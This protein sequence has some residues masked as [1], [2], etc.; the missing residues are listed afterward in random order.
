M[1]HQRQLAVAR[2]VEVVLKPARLAVEEVGGHEVCVESGLAYT[3][4][5]VLTLEAGAELD[6]S[7]GASG[8]PGMQARG[9]AHPGNGCGQAALPHPPRRIHSRDDEPRDTY[10]SSALDHLVP[11]RIEGWEVEVAVSIDVHGWV[12]IAYGV[13]MRMLLLLLL[14]VPPGCEDSASSGPHIDDVQPNPARPGELL[15]ITGVGFGERGYVGLG[16]LGVRSKPWSATELSVV[17]PTGT[18]GGPLEVVVLAEGRPSAP[19]RIEVLGPARRHVPPPRERVRIADARVVRPPADAGIPPDGAPPDVPRHLVARFTAD[20]G[21][22]GLVTLEG[23]DSVPGELRLR[24]RG[25]ITREDP[26]WGVAFHLAYD[27]NLLRFIE[28]EDPRRELRVM[29]KEIAPGQLAFGRVL[30][31]PVEYFAVLRFAL[32]GRGV[33]RVDF[34]PRFRTLRTPANLPRPVGWAGGSVQVLE[35]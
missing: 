12:R 16:G 34:P 29:V 11:V 5:G 23:L 31:G 35:R 14:L 20:G 21:G 1:E 32:V 6:R 24:V 27:R 13:L 4:G 2:K 17:L 33:G 26:P 30:P 28:I 3:A 15:R 22:N 9:P 25:P 7:L 8:H 10:G 19:F 18:G